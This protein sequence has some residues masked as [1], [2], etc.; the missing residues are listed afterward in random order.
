MNPSKNRYVFRLT[1]EENIKF[2]NLYEASGMSNKEIYYNNFVSERIKNCKSGYFNNR[3]SYPIDQ[4][5]LPIPVDWK[6]L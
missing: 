5:F 3:L 1:D 6:Q 2:L 4:I